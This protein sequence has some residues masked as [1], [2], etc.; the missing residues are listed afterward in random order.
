M[1]F[2]FVSSVVAEIESEKVKEYRNQRKIKVKNLQ[3]TKV[4]LQEEKPQHS[5]DRI[6]VGG[7]SFICSEVCILFLS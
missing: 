7:F 4:L 6:N 1:L 2:F 5:E 3:K